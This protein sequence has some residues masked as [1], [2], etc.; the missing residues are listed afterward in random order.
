MLHNM[1]KDIK[2]RHCSKTPFLVPTLKSTQNPGIE[3]ERDNIM[4]PPT[5]H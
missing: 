4:N 2:S 3:F 1:E 5:D